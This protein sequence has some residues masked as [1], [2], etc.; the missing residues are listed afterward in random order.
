MKK[1]IHCTVVLPVA[2]RPPTSGQ[3]FLVGQSAEKIYAKI[4]NKTI[5][6]EP[7][8]FARPCPRTFFTFSQCFTLEKVRRYMCVKK[9]STAIIRF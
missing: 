2:C 3:L 8:L 7:E 6:F 1:L 4:K 9:Y 5:I